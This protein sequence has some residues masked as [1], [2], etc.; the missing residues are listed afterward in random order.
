MKNNDYEAFIAAKFRVQRECGFEPYEI[1]APLFEW[2][3]MIVRWAIKQGRAA[4]FEECGLGKTLQ[5][6]EW[7]RQ[8]SLHT[9][10]AVLILCPLAVAEQTVNEGEKFGIEIKHV[11]QPEEIVKGVNITNYE[12]LHLFDEVAFAGVVLDESSILKSFNGKT[13]QQLTQRFTEVAFR[14][15]C[16]ATPSPNDFTELGQHAD[17]LG[18]CSPAEM[19]AT[20]FINDTFDTG[21]WRLK[22]HSQETFWRWVSSWAACV[23]KP[24][25]I[26]FDDAGYVLP[27]LHTEVVTVAVDHRAK[28]G[29]E[30]FHLPN[31]SATNLHSEM[32]RTMK[33]RVEAAAKI[34]NGTAEQFI[35]WT[36]SNEESNELALAIPDAVEV[37]GSDKPEHKEKKMR[38]FA[39]GEARVI[40]TKPSIAGFGLNWQH[41][42]NDIYVGMT[43][44]FER[45]YQA[46]KRIHRFGQTRPVN[47]Y[48]VQADTE[49][50]V[51]T[52]IMRKQE[53]H[54]TMR[55][56]M[57]FTRET[58][59][60]K[61]TIS[62][63]NSGIQ[64]KAEKNWTM[65]H[66][67]CVR[68]ARTMQSES[69]GFSVFSPPFADLFTYSSDIQDMG[70]CA[71]M[72]SFMK[73]F[74]FL[75][76]E[77]MRIMMPGRECAVH[78]CDLL[79]T[80]WKDG[81]I[82]F[83]DFS[84][85]I[86][87][88]F[89]ERGWLL[90]S[91]VC[92]WK[93]PVTEMQRTKAHGLLYKT[94]RTDSSKSRVGSADY[95]LVFR[96]PGENPKPITHTVETLPLDRWQELASPVWMTVDQGKVLNGK[97]ATEDKDERHICPLQLD[98]I[99]R[100]LTLWSAPD[101][102]VFSPFAGIGSE[103]YCAL[104]MGRRFIGVE[105]KESYF[106]AACC[107]LENATQ[108]PVLF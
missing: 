83:K 46:G 66:G 74:E 41:C 17:F 31:T 34:V 47:R 50:G 67:D 12:R 39:S 97:I 87:R 54:D 77:L 9:S 64:T 36:E 95:L 27:P 19:L 20:Y 25:D 56:L 28:G 93:D 22:G 107:N 13:R 89:R 2:Q 59:A 86:A 91:R 16:T 73:Q 52:A 14:L 32:R 26:G 88:C 18:I 80:K 82:E 48:I 62:I 23:S 68:V 60:G 76:D 61:S 53:Q 100:A 70:N 33:E 21:T 102:V 38:L 49:N 81:D 55:E 104:Q 7:A 40:V 3:K 108:Q 15:C 35:V 30:L 4:L 11:R 71:S 8:V 98:V 94:L 57:R 44:S 5:Q 43:H 58:L 24:S 42:R 90:H 103:G 72:E 105:L 96:K 84:G 85:T 45:F 6:I 75:V 99:E 101:D 106:K 1:D 92:I 10:G 69:V 63:M 51:M 65:H 29:E 78:C 37:T 79:A